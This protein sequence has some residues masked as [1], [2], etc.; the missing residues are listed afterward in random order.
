MIIK[1]K[2]SQVRKIEKDSH[3][4]KRFSQM[5]INKKRFKGILIKE[6]VQKDSH[7][8]KRFSRI[9]KISHSKN[10]VSQIKKDLIKKRFSQMIVSKIKC[11][12]I[13]SRWTG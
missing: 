11:V 8:K 5:I 2:F 6:E 13:N 1:K 3:K 4:K 9:K 12:Q 10:R 7:N